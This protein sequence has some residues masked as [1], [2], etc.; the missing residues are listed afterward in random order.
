MKKIIFPLLIGS[1]KSWL[2]IIYETNKINII[3]KASSSASSKEP[4]PP[5]IIK[6]FITNIIVKTDIIIDEMVYSFCIENKNVILI[7]NISGK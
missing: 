3:D 1:L 6:I 5:V 4:Q 7:N 2:I